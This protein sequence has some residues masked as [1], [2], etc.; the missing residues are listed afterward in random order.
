MACR[1]RLAELHERREQAQRRLQELAE[2]HA[3]LGERR[4]ELEEQLQSMPTDE[5]LRGSYHT[6]AGLDTERT[7]LAERVAT[8]AAR[9]AQAE[10]ERTQAEDA[11]R[12]S[13]E[14]LCLPYEDTELE[15]MR[16]GL[17]AFRVALAALWPACIALDRARDA[18]AVLG[19][20]V[21]TAVREL[22]DQAERLK[23][24]DS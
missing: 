4:A 15:A 12:A 1:A 8:A 24:A 7:R 18:A 13:A 21:E 16:A 11:A 3:R 6:L 14:E 2:A 20:D 10:S 17:Q 23:T 19:R 22:A 9:L 5:A